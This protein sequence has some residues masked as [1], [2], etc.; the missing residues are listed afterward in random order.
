MEKCY[1]YFDCKKT[2]CIMFTKDLITYNCWEIDETLCN[3]PQHKIF[4]KLDLKKCDVC[5]YYKSLNSN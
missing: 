4:E 3:H 2:D 1:E 5:I